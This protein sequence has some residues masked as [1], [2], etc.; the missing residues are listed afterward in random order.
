MT[1]LFV[2]G[3]L[4]ACVLPLP[5]VGRYN[6]LQSAE[7][8]LNRLASDVEILIQRRFEVLRSLLLVLS[9]SQTWEAGIIDRVTTARNQGQI[10]Q[11]LQE[12]YPHLR[13]VVDLSQLQAQLLTIETD[14][15]QARQVYNRTVEQ[16]NRQVS[17]FPESLIARHVLG[18]HQRPYFT[19]DPPVFPMSQPPS[20]QLHS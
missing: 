3:I 14:I 10:A 4:L 17:R 18:F 6:R 20:Q 11:V 5:F 16:F 13:S 9:H 19:A 1:I 7:H 2:L 12:V 8:E 15:A